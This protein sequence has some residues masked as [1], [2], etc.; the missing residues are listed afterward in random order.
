M[1]GFCECC[2]EIT[3]KEIMTNCVTLNLS[4]NIMHQEVISTMNLIPLDISVFQSLTQESSE[5][6]N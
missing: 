3:C 4:R 5:T 6:Y 2:D 1:V